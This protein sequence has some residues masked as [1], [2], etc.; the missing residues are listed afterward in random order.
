MAFG[1]EVTTWCIATYG[2]KVDK[3]WVVSRGQNVLGG[4]FFEAAATAEMCCEPNETLIKLEYMGDYQEYE[5]FN[6]GGA[7]PGFA[8]GFFDIEREEGIVLTP[9]SIH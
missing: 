2:N 4:S 8:L 1:S 6:S 5:V 9:K 3:R 7:A